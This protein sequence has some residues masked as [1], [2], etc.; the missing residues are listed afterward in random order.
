MTEPVEP[1]LKGKTILLGVTGGVAACKAVDVASRLNKLGASVDVILTRAAQN[2]VT[3][4][5]FEALTHRKAHT[6]MWEQ[7][8]YEPHHIAL[9][10]R[11]DLIIVAPAT[12][13]TMARMAHGLAEDLLTS[14]LLA[15]RAPILLAPAMNVNMWL[16]PA[17]RENSETLL[18]RGVEFVGPEE[19]RLASGKIGPGRMSEPEKIVDA[20]LARLT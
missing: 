6:D 19:G 13:N 4:L 1:I 18:R 10:E 12:A 9:S 8:D 2:F 3:A 11:P 15:T 7:H 5:S 14:V 17:T 16:H 20:A